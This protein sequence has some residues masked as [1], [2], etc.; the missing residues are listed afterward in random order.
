MLVR[1]CW[2]VGQRSGR[3]SGRETVGEYVGVLWHLQTLG[4]YRF[5]R[6]ILISKN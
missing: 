4:V 1:A 6:P 2:A 3:G 5:A